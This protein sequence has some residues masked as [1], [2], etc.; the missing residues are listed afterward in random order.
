MG[1]IIGITPT[2]EAMESYLKAWEYGKGNISDIIWF[3]SHYT[4]KGFGL[5]YTSLFLTYT[6]LYSICNL[7]AFD[8]AVRANDGTIRVHA[9]PMYVLFMVMMHLGNSPVYGR[10]SD[11][12]VEYPMFYHMLVVCGT[13]LCIWLWVRCENLKGKAR[14]VFYVLYTIIVAGLAVCADLLF[15]VVVF[16]FPFAIV[17]CRKWICNLKYVVRFVTGG[18]GL[19]ILLKGL[20]LFAPS[21]KALFVDSSSIYS[22]HYGIANFTSVHGIVNNI[23]NYLAALTGL[24]NFDFTGHSVQNLEI[25]V[26]VVRG[27]LCAF[28]LFSV[29]K[30][31]AVYFKKGEI[32]SEKA[33][34]SW[35]MFLLFMAYALTIWGDNLSHVRYLTITLPLGTIMLCEEMPALFRMFNKRGIRDKAIV[36]ILILCIFASYRHS[37]GEWKN[38]DKWDDDYAKVVEVLEERGLTYG[39]GTLTDCNYVTV[40]SGGKI[41]A[42]F[43]FRTPL[44]QEHYRKLPI[45]MQEYEKKIQ[46][47]AKKLTF[48]I[49]KEQLGF[50]HA[51]YQCKEFTQNEPV[52]LLLRDTIYESSTDIPCTKQLINAYCKFGQSLVAVHAVELE[53]VVHYG[54]FA[55]AWEDEAEQLMKLSVIAEK[56]SVEYARDFLNVPSRKKKENYYAAFGAYILTHEVFDRLGEMILENETS[57]GEIQLTDALSYVR[58]KYGMMGFVPQGKSFDIGNAKAYRETV[59]K[60]GKGESEKK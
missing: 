7:F 24:F 26:Y 31:I 11:Q 38:P 4:I 5:G 46:K 40:L 25:F 39:A 56:P 36:I 1:I 58:Q 57:G 29:G 59:K 51:V 54:I 30:Q 32:D 45:Q 18:L 19:V 14:I 12:F 44:A 49:P 16:V 35:S 48:C 3:I 43:I 41:Y 17:I 55:G 15:V 33:I 21:L 8:L 28:L 27:F 34:I 50:G 13:M 22:G 2:S 60:F 10:I 42:D 23:G 20:V 52:L 6:I 9:I 53:D 47:I 37:W